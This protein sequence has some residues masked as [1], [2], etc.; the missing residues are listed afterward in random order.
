[1]ET[2]QNCH[3]KRANRPRF[4]CFTCYNSPG[5]RD[6]YLSTSKFANP[7]SRGLDPADRNGSSARPQ[8]PTGHQPGTEGKVAEMERRARRWESLFDIRDAVIED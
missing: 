2:C 8:E 1:M 6:K 3:K 7:K 4:L 5:I